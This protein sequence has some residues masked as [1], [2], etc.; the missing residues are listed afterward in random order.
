[1]ANNDLE[2]KIDIT[3]LSTY[4]NKVKDI[5][6]LS[7]MDAPMY[8]RDFIVGQDTAALLLA[9]AIQADINA[10]AKLEEAESIAYL[11]NAKEYLESRQI[12]D[13]SEAR[14]RYISIDPAVKAAQDNKA[15]TEALVAL[16]KNK[17]SVL[18]QSHDTL[19]KI[20]YD[21]NKGT[22]WEGY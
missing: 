21:N 6:S 16:L 9:K 14:K 22:D 3:S 2:I 1:M 17:L 15:K 8:L 20:V 5:P 7:K 11:D 13:S 10:K 18:R 4:L 12:K 19:K